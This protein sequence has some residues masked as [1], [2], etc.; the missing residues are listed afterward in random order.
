MVFGQVLAIPAFHDWE[1]LDRVGFMLEAI[2]A[3]SRYM[4]IPAY[5]NV[6]LTGQL[7]RDDE[8]HEM[9]DIIFNSMVW[10]T[11]AIYDWFGWSRG[12]AFDLSSN[13][14]ASN[15]ERQRGMV[16]A[17]MQKT[18]DVFECLD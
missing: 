1:A 11:L 3:E 16:E 8:S 13:N 4:V 12:T 18:I 15:F 17:A 9:L 10:D 2:S 5:Y 6:Q 7:I 14:N